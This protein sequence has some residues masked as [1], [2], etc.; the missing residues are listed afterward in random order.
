MSSRLTL[1]A[2]SLMFPIPFASPVQAIA[3]SP[4][5]TPDSTAITVAVLDFKNSSGR[6]SL[7]V[8]EKSIPE[9]LKTEL[10]QNNDAILVVERQKL[11]MILQEQALGLSGV[12]DE[13]TAQ[14]VG[15]LAGAEYL[16]TGEISSTGGSRLRIDCHILK[17]E[18]GRV[19]GEKVIGPDG[20]A[21]DEMVHLLAVNVLFNLTGEGAH[22]QN[23]RVKNYPTS[24]FLLATALT[25]A[26]TGV[27]HVIS[28]DAYQDYQS[29]TDLDEFDKNYN[30]A[31]DFR[32]ARN[33]LAVASGALAMVSVHLWLKGRSEKNQIFAGMEPERRWRL[34]Q[35]TFHADTGGMQIGVRMHF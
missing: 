23:V 8:L 12:V 27:T 26:A 1:A 6:F 5:L 29:A 33:V 19:R 25:T 11:E 22:Q 21:L 3:P 13:K 35:M 7:D 17:V 16:L 24:W 34:Q 4:A 20:E 9:M 15:Q 14:M 28:N 30:R 10:S 2:L 18:S 32:K 31:T